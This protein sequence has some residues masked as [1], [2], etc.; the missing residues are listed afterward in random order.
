MLARPMERRVQVSDAGG[1]DD[2]RGRRKEASPSCIWFFLAVV[3]GLT[4]FGTLWYLV[5][6]ASSKEVL[7]VVERHG[8]SLCET[9]S[10]SA[11]VGV[12]E[13]SQ[14]RNVTTVQLNIVDKQAFKPNRAHNHL[15]QQLELLSKENSCRLSLG[16][17]QEVTQ[18]YVSTDVDNLDITSF[19]NWRFVM[20]ALHLASC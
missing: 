14:R 9:A 11:L 10:C 12:G 7:I 15:R 2:G 19:D 20:Y 4:V 8:P 1:A 5:R 6:P 18:G 3:L 16:A 17:A 13:A